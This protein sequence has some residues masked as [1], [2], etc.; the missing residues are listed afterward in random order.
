MLRLDRQCSFECGN[1]P[2]EIVVLAQGLSKLVVEAGVLRIARSHAAQVLERTGEIAGFPQGEAEVQVSA[3]AVRLQRERLAEDRNRL[4]EVT[5]GDQRR[6]EVGVRTAVGRIERDRLFERGDRAG[7]IGFLRERDTQPVVRFRRPRC[8]LDGALECHECT[9][10][11]VPL[12]I[13]QAE[14]DMQFGI[15]RTALDRRFELTYGRGRLFCLLRRRGPCRR[16]NQQEGE[17]QGLRQ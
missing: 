17:G 6:P 4:G 2:G 7:K 15:G 16:E 9:R 14:R 10:V 13:G 11:I 1:R 12:P 3:E 5:A 8:D